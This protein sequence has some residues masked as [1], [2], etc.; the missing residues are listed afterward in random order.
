[1]TDKAIAGVLEKIRAFCATLEG[2]EER[3]S[4][5][6]P[7]F[8]AGK[9]M[10]GEWALVKIKGRP[11]SKG[12]E[13]LL[14][15]HRDEFANPDVDVTELAPLSV[16]SNSSIDEIGASKRLGEP[17]VRALVR[18]DAVMLGHDD[19]LRLRARNIGPGDGCSQR[20]GDQQ[21]CHFTSPAEPATE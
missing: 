20:N 17:C 2:A 15:K 11:G 8:F 6:A 1:M 19:G 7:G 16:I 10:F 21:L 18:C 14:L 4:H 9:K 5:G 13:W 12:N 3:T